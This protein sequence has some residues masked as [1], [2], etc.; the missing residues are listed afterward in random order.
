MYHKTFLWR[1]YVKETSEKYNLYE[2]NNKIGEWPKGAVD[3]MKRSKES[4][5]KKLDELN[6]SKEKEE[7]KKEE[8]PKK[9]G[10]FKN[11]FK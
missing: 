7:P 1:S 5:N 2:F 4:L 3:M 9:Q 6:K 10:F 8:K 11:L